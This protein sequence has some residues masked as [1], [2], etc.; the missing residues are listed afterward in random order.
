MI[1]LDLAYGLL[2]GQ[3]YEESWPADPPPVGC[4]W[5]PVQR[6]DLADVYD[7]DVTAGRALCVLVG[8]PITPA[9][10]QHDD[11]PADPDDRTGC[12]VFVAVPQHP[13]RIAYREH[14]RTIVAETWIAAAA[15]DAVDQ[16]MPDVHVVTSVARL[17]EPMTVFSL[18]ATTPP[19]EPTP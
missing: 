13:T 8:S 19:T 5:V 11:P 9:W 6:D 3:T 4:E 14:D 10:G 17:D 16:V 1:P 12:D 15:G 18:T 2:V 7:G